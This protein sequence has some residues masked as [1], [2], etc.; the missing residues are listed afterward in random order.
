MKNILS[1]FAIFLVL[2]SCSSDKTIEEIKSEILL[3]KDEIVTLNSEIKEL[4]KELKLKDTT[5][6]QSN[7]TLV[8]VKNMRY[9]KFVHYF[10]ANGSV[11]AVN[12]AFIS[13]EI[14]GQIQKIHVDKGDK[15]S[16]NQLLVSLSDETIKNSIDEVLTQLSLAKILFEKQEKLWEKKIG[17]EV[18]YLELKGKKESLDKRLE[19]LQ[20]QLILHLIE[21]QL[22]RK[23]VKLPKI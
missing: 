12:A 22:L 8:S 19:T 5:N 6:H 20:S 14:N 4:E 16:E 11:E 7:N 21:S 1:L 10:E 13:S 15:V 9:E 23:L 17:S 18:Q 2:A 3:R